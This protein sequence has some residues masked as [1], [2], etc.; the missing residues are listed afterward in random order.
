[1]ASSTPHP[2]PDGARLMRTDLLIL[3]G[4]LLAWAVF[5]AVKGT[6]VSAY[7]LDDDHEILRLAAEL[8][9]GSFPEVLW[10]WVRDDVRFR[11]VYY[12][13]RV[14]EAW[15]FGDDFRAWGIYT[16]AL[17]AAVFASL[18]VALR[19]LRFPPLA[20][21]AFAFFSL[22]GDQFAIWWRIGP[23]ETIG[24]ACLSVA[25]LAWRAGA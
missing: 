3:A 1:M 10:R 24:M 13:H 17:G 25:C 15:A 22:C 12:S 8:R 5:F 7:H 20:A 19:W 23:N 14:A 18:Y 6:A 21:L 11:P 4:V 9:G 16:A 2:S